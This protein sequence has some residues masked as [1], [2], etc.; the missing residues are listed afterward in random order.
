MKAGF[1]IAERRGYEHFIFLSPTDLRQVCLLVLEFKVREAIGYATHLLSTR[2]SSIA[3]DGLKNLSNHFD[4]EVRDRAY[5]IRRTIRQ[6]NA[7]HLRIETLGGFRVYRGDALMEEKQW[8]RNQPKH[9]LM[10]IV[11]H[12]ARRIAKYNLIDDLWPDAKPASGDRN[13]KSAL[14]RLRKSLEPEIYEEFSSSYVHLHDNFVLLDEDLCS[15]DAAEFISL[16][17]KGTVKEKEGN[18]KGAL[19]FYAAAIELYKGDFLPEASDTLWADGKREELKEK[20]I[21]LLHATARLYERQGASRKAI[22]CYRK[23][24]SADPLVEE[25]Y[26]KLMTLYSSS[27]M[28]NEALRTYEACRT[29]LEKELKTAPDPLTTALYRKIKDKIKPNQ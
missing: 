21:E 22:D 11:A 24:I 25:S 19:A 8:D 7:P 18:L 29:A 2:L 1:E 14:H 9:L 20:Y 3:D 16:I 4:P 27:G 10:A 17:E 13:L 15:V 28:Y 5:Q 6:L 26:Q 12:G 23:A